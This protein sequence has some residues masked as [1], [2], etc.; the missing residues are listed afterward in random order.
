MNAKKTLLTLAA[1]AFAVTGCNDRSDSN[2]SEKPSTNPATS[3]TASTAPSTKP[4]TEPEPELPTELANAD[5]DHAGG[6][7]VTFDISD[8][9]AMN[10]TGLGDSIKLNANKTSILKL[11]D[12]LYREDFTITAND[13]NNTDSESD[14]AKYYKN[15]NDFI[16]FTEGPDVHNTVKEQV[17]KQNW[18]LLENPVVGDLDDSYFT[19]DAAAS[20]GKDYSVFQVSEEAKVNSES[21]A[22]FRDLESYFTDNFV[23]I[24]AYITQFSKLGLSVSA[25]DIKLDSLS[26]KVNLEGL[27]G[28][29][30][31]YTFDFTDASYGVTINMA[32]LLSVSVKDVDSTGLTLAD[33]KDVPFVK[34]ANAD[35]KY[36]AFDTA[37][38][39]MKNLDNGGYKFSGIIKEVTSKIGGMEGVVFKDG[40]SDRIYDFT[41]SGSVDTTT[42]SYSGVHKVKDGVFDYYESTTPAIAE[43]AKN[44]DIADVV[45][46]FDF[47]TE[48]FEFDSKK[49]KGE[50]YVFTLRDA[51]DPADVL[52]LMVL[53]VYSFKNVTSVSVHVTS[54]GVF[55]ELDFS[56]K[57]T[58]SYNSTLTTTYNVSL[59]FSEIG[60]VTSVPSDFATFD[61][62]VPYTEPKSY[63]ELTKG[64]YD[65][66]AKADFTGTAADAIKNIVGEDKFAS[67]PDIFAHANLYSNYAG[68]YYSVKSKLVQ[69][70]FVFADQDSVVKASASLLDGLEKAGYK[71]T[72]NKNNAYVLTSNDVSFMFGATKTD[73]GYYM[74]LVNIAPVS[75]TATN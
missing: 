22:K 71:F 4:S 31:K 16:A 12:G 58:S 2:K 13:G 49:S 5:F 65:G 38:S 41:D 45:P 59:T 63:A 74:L 17:I 7:D 35:D 40:Y 72:T 44:V 69:F 67:V 36:T 21:A 64:I 42:Y 34:T 56:F 53:P 50:D 28:F 62:Y 29:D 11:G 37:V 24:S 54:A 3:D 30:M 14:C 51:M 60:T 70:Q 47:S 66:D 52:P 9:F 20:K 23:N 25:S 61:S 27:I 19:Y 26:L 48:I 46:T 8:D 43:G 39:Q 1:L 68:A 32:S 10:M 55:K 6:N 75:N 18:A 57:G 33:C 15:A 73:D